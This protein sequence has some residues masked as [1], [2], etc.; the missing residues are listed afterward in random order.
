MYCESCGEA[1]RDEA[2][3]CTICGSPVESGLAH[4]DGMGSADIENGEDQ[5]GGDDAGE[6]ARWGS[7]L[8]VLRWPDWSSRLLRVPADPSAGERTVEVDRV[9]WA[10]RC[11]GCGAASSDAQ[12][13]ERISGDGMHRRCRCGAGAERTP[14]VYCESCDTLILLA[15]SDP[16]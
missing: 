9:T 5:A 6:G 7:D 10:W 11:D 8:P 13:F 4:G 14:A 15:S 12:D 16:D 3:F 2:R 1:L